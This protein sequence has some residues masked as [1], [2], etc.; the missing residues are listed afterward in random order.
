M[1]IPLI[2]AIGSRIAG[3]LASGG[4]FAAATR[5]VKNFLGNSTTRNAGFAIGGYSTGELADRL[6]VNTETLDRS[7]IVVAILGALIAIGQLF[8]IDLGI[9]L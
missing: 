2:G 5:G 8:N 4:A 3:G 7:L 1:P 6:G 9:D